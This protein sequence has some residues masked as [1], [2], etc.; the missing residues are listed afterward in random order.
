MPLKLVIIISHEHLPEMSTWQNLYARYFIVIDD[1]WSICTWS[2]IGCALPDNNLGSRILA[3]TRINDV[4]RSCSVQ[5][6]DFVLWMKALNDCDSKRLFHSRISVPE[7]DWQLDLKVYENM[8]QMCGGTP[9]AI[10]VTAGLLSLNFAKPSQ[11]SILEKAILSVSNQHSMI[12]GMEKILHISY[13]DL[14]LPVKSCF[15]YLSTFPKDY[16][17]RRD[18]LIRRWIAE[19][20]IPENS[21][22]C[23]REIGE[24]YFNELISRRLIQP[25]FSYDDDHAVGC[26][27][28]GVILDFIV[29]LSCRENFLIARED[30]RFEK[31]PCDVIRRFSL[32]CRGQGKVG[33][34]ANSVLHI[35]RVRSL[36]VYGDFS[37][38][39][40]IDLSAC[41]LIRVLDLE[42][43][44]NLHQ[45]E[46]I[47]NLWLLKYLAL[48][49]T[50][51][52]CIPE[53]IMALEHLAVLDLRRSY[54]T[55]LQPYVLTRKLVSLLVDNGE[56]LLRSMGSTQESLDFIVKG[57]ILQFE[58]I[59]TIQIGRSFN[60]SRAAELVNKSKQLRILGLRFYQGHYH[61]DKGAFR[62]GILALAR[63]VGKSVLQSLFLDA[64]PSSSLESLVD[65][66][67][68]IRQCHLRKFEL[69]L[70]GSLFKVPQRLASL[71]GLTHLHIDFERLEQEDFHAIGNLPKL[72]LLKLNPGFI[73]LN[74]NPGFIPQ[75]RCILVNVGFQCLKV[76][77]VEFSGISLKFEPGAMPQLRRLRFRFGA[78]RV[79]PQFGGFDFGIQH[80]SSLVQINATVNCSYASASEVES[81]EA[82][83]REQV[84]RIPDNPVLELNRAYEEKKDERI[85]EM[86]N[87]SIIRDL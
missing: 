30:L 76:L 85:L 9:L 66:W 27:V 77:L 75:H 32:N 6:I 51:V 53:Q 74:A 38:G 43:T 55:L 35:S 14:S 22:E 13:G 37:T 2:A 17:I 67:T 59:S 71:D 3:T 87:T 5:P 39:G 25:V 28:H 68:H 19:G 36:A 58:E 82:A 69:R 10:V 49:G 1:V 44:K 54:V 80:L 73:F 33:T 47:G 16:T 7:E 64:Y 34:M 11:S 63:E 72:V 61:Y 41:K 84:F 79:T 83:I 26:T 57:D 45:L 52:N 70:Y 18:C 23:S 8:M 81:A 65:S 56:V 40:M 46:S 48:G 12:Q 31:F 50:Y 60:F 29:S 20:F 24:T 42:G 15:M 86:T 21:E 78:A 4:A 62:Q